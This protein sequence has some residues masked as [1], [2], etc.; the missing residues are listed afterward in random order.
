MELR[1]E[2]TVDTEEL[3]VHNRR[4]RQ[5][6]ERFNAR[7]VNALTV[8]MLALQFEGKVVRKMATFVVTSQQP[9]GVGVPNLQGPEVKNALQQAKL[10]LRKAPQFDATKGQPIERSQSKHTSILKYPRST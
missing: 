7:L 8:L 3:L 4:Q 5:R 1:A 6:A 2:T 9:K 10:A